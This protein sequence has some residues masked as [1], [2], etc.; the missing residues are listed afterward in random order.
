MDD[1]IETFG[2]IIAEGE[3][4][5]FSVLADLE[6][7]VNKC[8][9]DEGKVMTTHYILHFDDGSTPDWTNCLKFSFSHFE[10]KD[11]VLQPTVFA[12]YYADWKE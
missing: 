12:V 5:P 3:R 2:N 10:V 1:F 11:T 9:R 7:K 4:C 6:A 8:W